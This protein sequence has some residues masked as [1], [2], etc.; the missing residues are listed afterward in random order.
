MHTL[1]HTNFLGKKHISF[2]FTVGNKVMILRGSNKQK[3]KMIFNTLQAFLEIT[4]TVSG[5]SLYYFNAIN[6][7][8]GYQTLTSLNCLKSIC[9]ALAAK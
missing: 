8:L 5:G 7:E 6:S 1:E 3:K 2:L 9:A 4:S